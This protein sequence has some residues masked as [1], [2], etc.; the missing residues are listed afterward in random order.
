MNCVLMNNVLT[1]CCQTI[2]LNT[3]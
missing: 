3:K 2:N 1:F